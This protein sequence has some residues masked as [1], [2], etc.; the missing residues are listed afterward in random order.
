MKPTVLAIAALGALSACTQRAEESVA[1][2]FQNTEQA[3]E[4]AAA[5]LE[6]ETDN[7]ARA[8]EAA[9]ANSADAFENRVDAI[10]VVPSNQ[11]ENKQ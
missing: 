9:L 11:A 5:A 4:N 6:A 2:Q 8:A 10:D 3:I 7:A 1:N